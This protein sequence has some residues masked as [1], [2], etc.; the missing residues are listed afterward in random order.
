MKIT[1]RKK[2]FLGFFS[3][4][5][6]LLVVG[7]LS[8]IVFNKVDKDY[9]FILNDRVYK[10]SLVN[11]L[12][13]NQK[14]EII[15]I[16]GYLLYGTENQIST[17]QEGKEGV[18]KNIT[19]LERI[20]K[21]DSGKEILK[22]LKDAN[23]E[24]TELAEASI[25]A[26]SNGSNEDAMDLAEQAL[27]S[28]EKLTK[29]AQE[30]IDYQN[31]LRE[32][33]IVD[34]NSEVLTMSTIIW[35]LIGI[36]I[37][38]G[39]FIAFFTSGTISKPILMVRD[40]LKEVAAGNLTLKPLTIKNR[41]EIGEMVQDLNKMVENL[42]HIITKVSGS[43]IEVAAQAEELSASTEESA[44]A[45]QLMAELAQRNAAG[46]EKQLT[47]ISEISAS[48][49]EM[50]MGI[51]SI[52]HSGVEML[53]A[54]EKSSEIIKLGAEKVETSSVQM[55]NLSA[56]IHQISEIVDELSL[57]SNEI[58]DITN[59]INGIADQTNLLALNAAIEAA[60]AGEAGKGFAVVAN[61]VRSLAEQSKFSSSQ[62]AEMILNIQKGVTEA[63]S[64][65]QQGNLLV[66]SSLSSTNDILEVFESIEESS[67]GLTGKINEVASASEQINLV[68]TDIMAEIEEVLEVA[69][70]ASSISNEAGAAT[71]EQVATIEQISA[72]A[73]S[74]SAL[75]EQLQSVVYT[76]R[77]N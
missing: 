53:Q 13:N 61:E 11:E 8:E 48:I 7:I 50:T 67:I 65:I 54:N 44:A 2:M 4:L 70:E 52:A 32:D 34:L 35:I 38:T 10:V 69:K 73:Q 1:V 47:V 51:T 5:F 12:M 45:S 64:S 71:E 28:S 41:D 25:K 18:I 30:L 26:K 36:S 62:I 15:G 42:S 37:L 56:A 39:G 20:V 9:Q 31:Q 77:I 59:I 24:Y 40:T 3:I 33:S 29:G 21:S 22:R 72:S 63:I 55:N 16:R 17:Y 23:F 75:S 76:F 43:A 27:K 68:A 19:E 57:K 14:V 74:L 46:S 66:E 60:R 49:T 6:L 58:S